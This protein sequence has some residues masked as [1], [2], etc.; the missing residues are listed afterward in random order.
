MAKSDNIKTNSKNL[1]TS[2]AN[3][4]DAAQDVNKKSTFFTRDK[5]ALVYY[6]FFACFIDVLFFIV[7]E[8]G[9]IPR[10]PLFDFVVILMILGLVYAIPNYYVQCSVALVALLFQ[11]TL[12]ITNIIILK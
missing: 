12:C 11:C 3:S 2:I 4:I 7:M 10:Y 8:W 5:I 1:K 9:A 6:F